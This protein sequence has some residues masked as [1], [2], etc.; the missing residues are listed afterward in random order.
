M[1]EDGA[2]APVVTSVGIEA[3]KMEKPTKK[4]FVVDI[5]NLPPLFPTHRHSASF[6]EH[7]G[8]TVATF[9]LLEEVL[10]KAIFALTGTVPYDESKVQEAVEKWL[11]T[12]ER[13]LSDALGSLIDAYGKAYRNHPNATI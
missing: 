13:A 1:C 5:C 2:L 4:G 3:P 7:L 12:L 11:P 9:G 8:R 6:W 10:G